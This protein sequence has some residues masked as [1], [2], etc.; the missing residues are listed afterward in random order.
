MRTD[1]KHCISKPKFLHAKILFP[2][3]RAVAKMILKNGVNWQ[4]PLDEPWPAIGVGVYF[5]Y[6]ILFL[7]LTRQIGNKE[8]LAIKNMV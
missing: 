5:F 1:F 4:P 3:L 8:F 2:F 6:L 7:R